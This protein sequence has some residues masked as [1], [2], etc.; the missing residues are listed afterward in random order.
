MKAEPVD[1][2]LA[3]QDAV[4]FVRSLASDQAETVIRRWSSAVPL[5]YKGPRDFAT[6]VDLEV[7][8]NLKAALGARFPDHELS[9]EE[10]EDSGRASDY[11]WLIDPIDGTKYY[12]GQSSLFAVSI[13]LAY[14][15]E[16]I[17]GVVYSAASRQCFYAWAGG[18]AFLDGQRIAGSTV[19]DLSE[20]IANVDTP[21]T[22]RL[23]AA[24]R[25]WFEKKL[26]TLTRRIYRVRALGVGSLAACW[27]ASGALDAYVDLTGRVK[28]QDVAAGRIIMKEAG[29]R[30]EYIQPGCGPERLVAAP[31]KLWPQLRDVLAE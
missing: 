26:V 10:T 3:L 24:E 4:H 29:M 19:E 9:G 15:G 6:Q 13:G 5:T 12:R 11:R 31:P 1:M 20:A 27:L 17:L 16:P 22:D 18:G 8:R 25:E 23:P 14:R 30:V 2:E 21:G 28:P 7:E